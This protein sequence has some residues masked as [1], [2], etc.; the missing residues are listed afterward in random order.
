MPNPSSCQSTSPSIA[1]LTISSQFLNKVQ[2]NTVDMTPTGNLVRTTSLY[3]VLSGRVDGL[4]SSTYQNYPGNQIFQAII[5]ENKTQYQELLHNQERAVM[6]ASSIFHAIHRQGGRFLRKH[7]RHWLELCEDQALFLTCQALAA[8]DAPNQPKRL[9]S[10]L[11]TRRFKPQK[12]RHSF[13]P[14]ATQKS[15]Y[16]PGNSNDALVK[17]L[18]ADDIPN[19]IDN[20]TDNTEL[21]ISEKITGSEQMAM[22]ATTTWHEVSIDD[23][24][25][26]ISADTEDEDDWA[27][28]SPLDPDDRNASESVEFYG[29]CRDLLELLR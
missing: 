2:S 19:L 28:L 22:V 13:S 3:D 7:G 23:L 11:V 18:Y 24:P 27:D 6:L 10:S 20:H 14:S 4:D 15:S 17:N 26:L 16:I 8:T 1:S 21:L 12:K 29:L 5:R 9:R 25:T